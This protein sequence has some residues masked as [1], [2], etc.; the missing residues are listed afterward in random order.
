MALRKRS[1]VEESSPIPR[2]EGESEEGAGMGQC[3]LGVFRAG[4]R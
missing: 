4:R 1:Q 2:D 3:G